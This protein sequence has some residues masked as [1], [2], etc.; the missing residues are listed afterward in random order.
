MDNFTIAQK[1]DPES[2]FSRKGKIDAWNLWFT[3][4]GKHLQAQKVHIKVEGRR[5]ENPEY[6]KDDSGEMVWRF[7]IVL[8]EMCYEEALSSPHP[9]NA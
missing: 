8:R 7:E 3:I 6:V 5:V 1:R 2:D 9:T 4:V